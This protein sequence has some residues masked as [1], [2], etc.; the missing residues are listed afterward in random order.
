MAGKGRPAIYKSKAKMYGMYLTEENKDF[1]VKLAEK[2][3]ARS[4]SA[5][6]NQWV[7]GLRK[8]A[9]AQKV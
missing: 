9:A 3:G 1:L 8:K 7:D 4:V 2:K 5:L 6:V